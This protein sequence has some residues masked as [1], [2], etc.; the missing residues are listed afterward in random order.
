MWDELP[1][2]YRE[3]GEGPYWYARQ[4]VFDGSVL[5]VRFQTRAE[6]EAAML[7]GMELDHIWGDPPHLLDALFEAAKKVAPS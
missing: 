3:I 2:P 4:N 5:V 7:K 1:F 6:M